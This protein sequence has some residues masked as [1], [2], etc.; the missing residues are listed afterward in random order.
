MGGPVQPQA[1]RQPIA[2]PCIKVCCVEP[3]SG[4]CLGCHRT[5]PEIAAWGRLSEAERDAVLADLPAR[6]AR[7]PAPFRPREPA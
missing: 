3:T 5:L 6:A 4:L 2:S 1:L 7:L